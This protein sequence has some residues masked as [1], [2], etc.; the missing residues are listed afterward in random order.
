M[1]VQFSFT[2]YICLLHFAFA[3]CLVIVCLCSN[4]FA[5]NKR[6]KIRLQ[7]NCCFTVC[8]VSSLCIYLLHLVKRQLL[9]YN[10]FLHCICF[11]MCLLYW[12]FICLMHM[13]VR[14]F[15]AYGCSFLLDS[16]VAY[17]LQFSV[18][19]SICFVFGLHPSAFIGQFEST[20]YICII[21]LKYN[22]NSNT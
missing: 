13:V 4:F 16:C 15:A 21:I 2:I 12:L 5:D 11:S 17:V 10:F 3:L 19:I 18:C 1:Q 14:L 6:E 7:F 22:C 9:F 20:D 8:F